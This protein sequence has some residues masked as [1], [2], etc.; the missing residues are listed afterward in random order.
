MRLH[1]YL[2]LLAV[3]FRKVFSLHLSSEQKSIAR[4]FQIMTEDHLYW[5]DEINIELSQ[6]N[7]KKYLDRL[8]V[9]L[10]WRFKGVLFRRFSQSQVHFVVPYLKPLVISRIKSQAKAHGMGRHSPAQVI[11]TG[12]KDLRSPLSSVHKNPPQYNNNPYI[13]FF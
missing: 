8:S 1:G 9:A 4:P 13:P 12:L 3:K 10:D 11:E 7:C 2:E 5:S 6:T